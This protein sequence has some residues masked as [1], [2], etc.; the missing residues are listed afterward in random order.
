MIVSLNASGYDATSVAHYPYDCFFG[1]SSNRYV[2]SFLATR[3]II[4]RIRMCPHFHALPRPLWAAGRRD[5]SLQLMG[6]RAVALS[7]EV[8]VRPHVVRL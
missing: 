7:R 2:C 8:L 1:K 3:C 4:N 6:D 5:V